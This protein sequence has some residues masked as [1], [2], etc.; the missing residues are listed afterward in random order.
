MISGD[1][2]V[3]FMYQPENLSDESI[4]AIGEFLH[5]ICRSFEQMN[6]TQL[7]R[8]LYS[9]EDIISN[10]ECSVENEDEPF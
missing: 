10:F 8:V 2:P 1:S 3:L 7:N 4:Q 5:E 9:Q 6:A